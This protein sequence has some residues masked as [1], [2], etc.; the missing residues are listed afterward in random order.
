MTVYIVLE[1]EREGGYVEIG[2]VEAT[3]DLTAIRRA[4]DGVTETTATYVAIP[5]RSWKPRRV[6][7]ETKTH[8]KI[9]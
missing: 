7:A 6:E 9:T 1:K 8:L 2:S 3:T 5:E 4:L